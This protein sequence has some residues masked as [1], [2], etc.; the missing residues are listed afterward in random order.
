MTI[1]TAPKANKCILDNRNMLVYSSDRHFAVWSHCTTKSLLDAMDHCAADVVVFQFKTVADPK[2]QAKD[3]AKFGK[4]L[5][6]LIPF[7]T[8]GPWRNQV[9]DGYVMETI[10][11]CE[12]YRTFLRRG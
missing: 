2:E 6:S 3:K 5:N 7:Y 11:E 10:F 1:T 4:R 8:R 12:V 9:I